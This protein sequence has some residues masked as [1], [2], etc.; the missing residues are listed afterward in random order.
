LLSLCSFAITAQHALQV[1]PENRYTPYPFLHT[2]FNSLQ[3]YDR[4]LAEPL[5]KKLQ[6]TGNKRV[7][8]LY[9]GDSHVQADDFTGELRSRFQLAYGNAG[10]GMVFPY[11]TAR[12]HAAVD[13][14]TSHTGRWLNAKNIEASP[15]LPLGVSGVS[16]RTLDSD[17]SFR[18]IFKGTV[19]PEHTRLRIF[20]KR[21][22][23]SY[24]FNVRSG[25]SQVFVDVFEPNSTD[26]A[27]MV[28]VDLPSVGSD[29]V[30]TLKKTDTSQ[31]MF[32]IYGISIEN[33]RDAGVLFH[34]VGIN[35]AGHYSLLRQ[36]MMSEQ[37][38][39]LKPDAI[40]IDLGANDFYR[41]KIDK[42]VFSD[43]LLKIVKGIRGALP[44]VSIILG[45]SQDIYRGGYSLTDCLAFSDVIREFSNQHHCLFYDWYWVSGGRYSMMR[46]SQNALAK[47]DMVHLTHSGYLLKGQLMAESYERTA[48]WL[49]HNDTGKYLV[50]NVDSLRAPLLDT[51]PKTQ[52]AT[53]T[54][55]RYQWLYHRV[56]RGQT[57]WS[58][59]AAYGVSAYQIKSWN[60][61]RSNYLWI[62]QILKIYAPIKVQVPI[63]PVNP[64]V[65]KPIDS[66]EITGPDT[67]RKVIPKPVVQR[68]PAPKPQTRPP[69]PP[70]TPKAL[71]HKVRSGETLFSI[72]KKYGSSTSAIMKLNHMKSH[73]LRAGQTI[74]VK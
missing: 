68:P 49:K 65:T 61:L 11:S 44:N 18:M 31:S 8:I 16:S 39:M 43:N 58:V 37:L 5:F 54:Q 45:C 42:V 7:S 56:L 62:G 46:W 3:F 6:N 29:F 15:Q 23:Q 60:R 12:T 35:G 9:I 59:A 63:K 27:Q 72:S 10:R 51:T 67:T 69:L 14:A 50:Y 48:Y 20:L 22:I 26:T 30:F 53:Q 52:S 21:D 74:R 64:I 57:I 70:P 41:G 1:W 71:Y 55:I 66:T 40:I 17:A 2:E 4:A 38:G 32:E 13:Y 36:N 33:P 24:D 25:G 19:Q 34:S 73:N 28:V 47:W